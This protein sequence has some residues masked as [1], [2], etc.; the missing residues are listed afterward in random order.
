MWR[1]AIAQRYGCTPTEAR[2]AQLL[3][4]G[5]DLQQAARAMAIT[6]GSA[7]AYLKIVFQKI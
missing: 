1:A 4:L 3:A 6:D 2:L 7:R 5:T